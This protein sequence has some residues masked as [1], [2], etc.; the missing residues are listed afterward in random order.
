MK[1]LLRFTMRLITAITKA[2]NYKEIEKKFQLSTKG[3]KRRDKSEKR[4]KMYNNGM[5]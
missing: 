2:N 5:N 4:E 3:K 1:D